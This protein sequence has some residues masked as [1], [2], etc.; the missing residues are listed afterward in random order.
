MVLSWINKL[1]IALVAGVAIIVIGILAWPLAAPEDPL[2]PVRASNVGPGGTVVLLALAFSVG[3]AGYFIAWPHG[4]EIGILGVPF[5]LALWAGRSGPMRTLT[6]ALDEPFE[7][8]ALLGSLNVEPFYWLLIVA[9]GFAGVL[10]AQ[11]LR[12]GSQPA[13]TVAQVKSYLKPAS[14]ANVAIALLVGTLLAH[15]FLGVFARDLTASDN[16]VAP[17]PA[18]GQ[19]IFAVIA[20]F[21]VAA[22][23]VKKF[24]GLSYLWPAVASIL[25]IPFAK[26]VYYKAETIQSFVETQPATSFPR[27]VFA[28]L[29]LQLVALGALGSVLGYWMAV[30]YDFWRKH[31]SAA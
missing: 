26:T 19:I 16:H 24:L 21:G 12:P 18:V 4:R 9:A 11:Y 8:E 6:Q 15:F 14:C 31:E 13:L 17:Q 22:F 27:P 25:V 5:A 2:A 7:R 28:I 20:A 23:A 30:R 10:A 29:P 3:F 1:R